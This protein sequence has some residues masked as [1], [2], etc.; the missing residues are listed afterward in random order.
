MMLTGENAFKVMVLLMR[1]RMLLHFCLMIFKC[2]L[3][4]QTVGPILFI[5]FLFTWYYYSSTDV[6]N[7][8]NMLLLLFSIITMLNKVAD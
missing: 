4:Y 7:Q 2:M 6:R 1:L 5:P 8:R 3:Y